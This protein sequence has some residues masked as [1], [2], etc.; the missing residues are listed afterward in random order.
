[1]RNASFSLR[2]HRFWMLNQSLINCFFLWILLNKLMIQGFLKKLLFIN[3]IHLHLRI[4]RSLTF[5]VWI[6]ISHN[7]CIFLLHHMSK[8]KL[9]PDLTHC[10][11]TWILF[12]LLIL[13][14]PFL[15]NYRCNWSTLTWLRFYI[16]FLLILLNSCTHFF[17][18]HFYSF[19]L[20]CFLFIFIHYQ[21]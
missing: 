1:M 3:F 9:S 16:T 2:V 20:L 6:F 14:L 21:F 19:L 4:F 5:L 8:F 17:Y 12:S 15:L 13:W 11:V 7:S 18:S 10:N